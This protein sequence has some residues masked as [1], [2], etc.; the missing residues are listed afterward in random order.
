MLGRDPEWKWR[1]KTIAGL[2]S[3]L[4]SFEDQSL[5]VRISIDD[6]D[7][8]YTISLVGKVDGRCLLMNCESVPTL[9][10]HIPTTE[11]DA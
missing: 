1:G 3:E 7:T 10:R 2:I 5:E 6:G 11:T 8:S 9:L 4:Q